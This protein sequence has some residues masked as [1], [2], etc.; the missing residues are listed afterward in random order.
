MPQQFNTCNNIKELY[1]TGIYYILNTVNSKFY[2]GSTAKIGEYQ[3]N[4]GFY[5]RWYAHVW[6]LRKNLHDNA[7]LQNAWNKYGE[8]SFKFQILEFVEPDKCLEVEQIY[9]DLFPEG[10]RESVYNISFIAGCA[11]N[12]GQKHTEATRLKMVKSQQQV[13][14]GSDFYIISPDGEEIIGFNIS[15][16]CRNNNLD[17]GS[18]TRVLSGK[19]TNHKGWTRDLSTRL[20][21]KE[22]FALRGLTKHNPGWRVQWYEGENKIPMSKKCKDLVS[23]IELRDKLI[24]EGYIF[25]NTRLN[26]TKKAD[27]ETEI[28]VL[29][30]LC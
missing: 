2:I 29:N 17:T 1:S 5:S 14:R 7:H 16:L 22:S 23:A 24:E 30:E 25:K 8:E 13:K 11:F 10:D 26:R 20:L 21:Y 18:I 15:A 19:L 27:S 9:L 4:S 12:L 28:K 3:S 6:G